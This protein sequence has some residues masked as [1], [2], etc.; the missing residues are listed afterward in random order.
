MTPFSASQLARLNARKSPVDRRVDRAVSHALSDLG[1]SLTA[2]LVAEQAGMSTSAFRRRFKALYGQPFGH[3]LR[4][5]R[6]LAAI[7]LLC[8]LDRAVDEI[9]TSV[10]YADSRSLRRAFKK[11]TAMTPTEW[12]EQLGGHQ[13]PARWGGPAAE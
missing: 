12:R 10:G 7:D 4:E 11:V 13:P 9:A 8:V 1:Q 6:V 2:E 5:Q 3:W